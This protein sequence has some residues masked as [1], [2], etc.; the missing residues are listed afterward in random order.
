MKRIKMLASA[1][2]VLAVVGGALAFKAYDPA[3]N[4]FCS[5]T[6]PVQGKTCEQSSFTLVNFKTALSG[7]TTNP[8]I[9]G[10]GNPY[11]DV[12]GQCT[13]LDKPWVSGDPE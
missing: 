5:T 13:A 8:C 11:Y 4:I 7:S 12:S 3:A 2:A 1:F 9:S 10:T 6:A